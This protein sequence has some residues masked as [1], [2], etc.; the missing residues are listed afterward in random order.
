MI[1]KINQDTIAYILLFLG[2]LLFFLIMRRSNEPINR[3]MERRCFREM[4]S[5]YK[6]V[7]TKKWYSI[8]GNFYNLSTK[9]TFFPRCQDIFS[10]KLIETGDSLYKPKGT[11]NFYIY[12]NTNPD[13]V[14]FI[15]CDFDC[16]SY[17]IEKDTQDTVKYENK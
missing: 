12:K 11:F 16:K 9:K 5:I 14:I 1:N 17:L 10:D 13:S 2:I 3:T 6:G 15:E 8:S 4:N 7:V